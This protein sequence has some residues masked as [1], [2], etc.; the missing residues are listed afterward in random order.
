MSDER[1]FDPFFGVPL[2]PSRQEKYRY[3]A[4]STLPTMTFRG[5]MRAGSVITS[6]DFAGPIYYDDDIYGKDAGRD[7]SY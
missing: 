6:S 4:R 5:V 1:K 7:D 2:I 3:E